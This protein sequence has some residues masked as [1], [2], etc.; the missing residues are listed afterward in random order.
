MKKRKNLVDQLFEERA[1]FCKMVD[2]AC[3]EGAYSRA[4][5]RYQKI[6][7][8]LQL[9]SFIILRRLLFLFGF[10]IG[11]LLTKLFIG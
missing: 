8:E 2:E 7:T 1:E 9:F 3:D 5:G 6:V 11:A 4:N 10:L